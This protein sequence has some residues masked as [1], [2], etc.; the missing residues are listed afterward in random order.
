MSYSKERKEDILSRFHASGMSMRAACGHFADFPHPQTLAG[1]IREEEAGLLSPP[2]LDVPGR[3]DGHAPWGTYPLET[4]KEAIRLLAEGLEAHHVAKRLGVASAATVRGWA[5]SLGRLDKLDSRSHPEAMREQAVGLYVHGLGVAEAAERV[6]VDPRTVGKWLDDAGIG[7]RR[8]ERKPATKGAVKNMRS[9]D[10]GLDEMP[11]PS[12]GDSD[13]GPGEWTRAWGDL[14]DDDPAERA[15][16]AEVRL[17]E[18]LA[19][20]DVLKAPGP[21]SLSNME[22]RRVGEMA[23]A[24][25]TEARVDDVLRDLRIAR[26]TYFSQAGRMG[27]PDKYAALRVRVR[28]AF[29]GSKRRY[30]SESIWAKLREGDGAPVGAAELQPGDD[31]TPVIVSEKVIRA[32]MREEGLVP[33]QV[34]NAGGS[35]SSYKGEVDERPANLPLREDGTHD[36]HADSPGRLVV[37]DVTEFKLDGYKVYLSPVIDCFDGCPVSWR[38]S[39]HPDDEL[40]A[41]SLEDALGLLVEGCVVHT[42][43]GINYR[44]NRWKGLCEGNGLVRSMSRKAKSPD[45]ARAEGFFGTLKQE[46]FHARDWKGVTKGCFLRALNEYI[47]WYRDE[48]IKKSL[49]WKTIAAYRAAHEGAA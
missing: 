35:Y 28:A 12:G 17:A 47:I 9:E 32:I 4:K 22:K 31:E 41:G 40:T 3:C 13:D 26:S 33:V 16:L 1:F 25:A 18:A 19:V 46:F 7:R 45:N 14:P 21:G 27:R 29:E 23:R 39:T 38:A 8:R 2:V 10:D 49:G 34:A 30:G 37:T 11:P 5:A 43:G 20:L 36:F 48:K 15:R 24:M 42:D 6:G 44:S